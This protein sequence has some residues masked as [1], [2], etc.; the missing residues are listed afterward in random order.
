MASDFQRD[1]V[2][3]VFNAMDANSDGFLEEADF[4]ALTDRWIN[5]RGCAPGSEDHNRLTA[6]MMGWWAV[7]LAASDT[8]RDNKVTLDEVLAVVDRLDTMTAAVNET[9]HAMFEAIDADADGRISA[10]EY[11]QLIEAWNGR[12]T[13]TDEV[14]PLLDLDG[15]GYVTKT[16]FTELW[17]EF[18]AGDDQTSPGKLV[19]GTLGG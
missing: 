11:R 6:I 5:L 12:E 18:W 9:A 2:I 3:G 7:L 15:D 1:K 19:F 13:D 10:A 4:Q 8:D 16:E 17:R 14:F